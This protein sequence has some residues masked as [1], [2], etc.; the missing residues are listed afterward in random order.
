MKIKQLIIGA[1]LLF[2]S[3][4]IS[5]NIYNISTANDMLV[6]STL[7][8]YKKVINDFDQRKREDLVQFIKSNMNFSKLS[9]SKTTDL[10]K[11]IND[12]FIEYL[13]NKNGYIQLGNLV[14]KIDV[15]QSKCAVTS[16]AYYLTLRNSLDAG[17]YTDSKIRA[18]EITDNVIQMIENDVLP[19]NARLFCGESGAGHD[20]RSL[21]VPLNNPVNFN[22]PFQSCGSMWGKVQY[23]AAGVY[24]RLFTQMQNSCNVSRIILYHKTPVGGKVK[25]GYSWGPQ[26]QWDITIGSGSPGWTFN[27]TYYL[28]VQPLNAY[29]LRIVYM[30]KNALNIG[31]PDNPSIDLE[32]RRNM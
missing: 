10:Y 30:A 32:I 21:T 15:I 28:N 9:D 31:D 24:F 4:L 27:D 1:V 18:Y 26:Y 19:A 14:Y 22:P 6:F 16:L 29:W 12:E 7:Q 3:A 13:V 2:S 25:C 8:D 20:D 17:I 5:Q 11:K 23:T